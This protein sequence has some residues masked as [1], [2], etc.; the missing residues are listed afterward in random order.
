MH[1]G[2]FGCIYNRS[3]V[4]SSRDR[5]GVSAAAVLHI[6]GEPGALGTT[7]VLGSSPASTVRP[8]RAGCHQ[9]PRGRA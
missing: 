9:R 3:A 1:T 5:A 6:R 2:I 8:S 4:S 7:G